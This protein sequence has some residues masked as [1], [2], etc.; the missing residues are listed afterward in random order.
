MTSEKRLTTMGLITVPA[1]ITLAITLV[2]LAGERQGWS[3]LWFNPDP[4]G[5]FALIGIV[6]LVPIFGVYFAMKL[7]GAGEGPARTGRV[8]LLTLLSIVVI[9]AGF[10]LAL[11]VSQPG[12]PLAQ[13]IVGIASIT[14][15]VIQHRAWP[16]LSKA[17]VAYGYAARIPVTIIMFFAIRGNWGTHYDGP[18]PG[19]PADMSWFPKFILIGAIPQ[20]IMWIAFTSIVGMLFGAIAVAVAKR[21]KQVDAAAQA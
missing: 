14:A 9:V 12:V 7:A 2:R 11:K 16:S 18:P 5:G 1:L 20:L 21:D 3:R 10:A 17:L 4:G 6:W 13:A 15:L 19:F 8:F